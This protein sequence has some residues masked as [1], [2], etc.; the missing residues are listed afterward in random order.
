MKGPVS[1][2]MKLFALALVLVTWPAAGC[3]ADSAADFQQ[4]M[5]AYK[6]RHYPEATAL[7]RKIAAE[8]P[9]LAPQAQFQLAKC[10]FERQLMDQAL[11]AALQS[12]KLA[13]PADA[14]LVADVKFKLA[15]W[16]MKVN[17]VD[18][19][20]PYIQDVAKSRPDAAVNIVAWY[21]P[22]VEDHERGLAALIY[23]FVEMAGVEHQKSDL[24]SW[25]IPRGDNTRVHQYIQDACDKLASGTP[26]T[27][28]K[29]LV[30]DLQAFLE[31]CGQADAAAVVA[32]GQVSANASVSERADGL[33]EVANIRFRGGKYKEAAKDLS[34][35]L[36]L[37][38]DVPESLQVQARYLL[39][40]CHI[41]TGNTAAAQE[42]LNKILTSFP[43]SKFAEPAQRALQ[44]M[45]QAAGQKGG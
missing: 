35:V 16:Y 4:A 3:L 44:G 17:L 38:A 26:Y 20:V 31:K 15:Q 28:N 11:S 25:L 39:A 29:G 23:G 33:F 21:C 10:Y 43:S 5:E 2:F 36:A 13:K 8:D 30:P 37:G 22:L 6:A 34:D 42:E 45:G 40:M 18:K 32:A 27:I 24:P 12:L 14:A 19:A 41:Q 7:F 9:A 1:Q